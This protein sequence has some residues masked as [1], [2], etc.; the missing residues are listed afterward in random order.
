MTV[1]VHSLK[2]LNN[3]FG[4]KLKNVLAIK[5]GDLYFQ[6]PEDLEIETVQEA[7][8]IFT[9]TIHSQDELDTFHGL[10]NYEWFIG[11]CLHLIQQNEGILY[12]RSLGEHGTT[13]IHATHIDQTSGAPID[14]EQDILV[15]KHSS[16]SLEATLAQFLSNKG[17][18]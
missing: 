17:I 8:S 3:G 16:G 12:Y 6:L 10:Q 13:E 11:H 18:S 1:L 4:M 14:A 15:F 7:V 2:I 5:H 9:D